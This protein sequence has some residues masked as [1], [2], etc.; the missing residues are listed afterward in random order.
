MLIVNAVLILLASISLRLVVGRARL[1]K[2]K[3][4]GGTA[5]S[6]S[7]VK[8]ICVLGLVSFRLQRHL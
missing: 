5:G 2:R 6:L 4:A 7:T 3:N 8:V 1:R